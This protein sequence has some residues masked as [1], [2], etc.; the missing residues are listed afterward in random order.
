VV[1]AA[2]A[3]ATQS[4]IESEAPRLSPAEAGL[5]LRSDFNNL[6]EVLWFRAYLLPASARRGAPRRAPPPR[7]WHAP[8][9]A[10]PA[11]PSCATTTPWSCAKRAG[12]AARAA[13]SPTRGWVPPAVRR[14]WCG[15]GEARIHPRPRRPRPP[16]RQAR[17]R[18]RGVRPGALGA[19]SRFK[20]PSRPQADRTPIRL[21]R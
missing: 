20:I 11:A 21:R 6:G 16:A 8:R 19:A 4:H 9:S 1:I 5:V 15:S 12:Q 2:R 13:A 14:P 10:T 3:Y 7:S 18:C 17:S